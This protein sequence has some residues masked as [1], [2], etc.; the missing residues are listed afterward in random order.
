MYQYIARGARCGVQIIN[1]NKHMFDQ[2]ASS[3]A[4]YAP[5]VPVDGKDLSSEIPSLPKLLNI[6]PPYC[7]SDVLQERTV[8]MINNGD[9]MLKGKY[10]DI[11]LESLACESYLTR[12]FFILLFLRGKENI[13][14][15][16]N[17]NGGQ[18]FHIVPD[19]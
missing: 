3:I 11:H 16:R 9:Y 4:K 17:L 5:I 7:L 6:K 8:V 19:T 2:V 15:V 10:A 18:K 12:K 13:K 14:Y 1:A